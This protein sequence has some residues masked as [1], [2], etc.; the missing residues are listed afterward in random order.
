MALASI[1][2]PAHAHPGGHW[3][4]D[5]AAAFDTQT[6]PIFVGLS[7]EL[8]PPADASTDNEQKEAPA[9]ALPFTKFSEQVKLR[10]DADYLYVESD[11]MPSH[12]MMI[13]ITAWQQQVPLPQRYT[14]DNAWQIPLHPVPAREP[15]S[16]KEHFF[17]GAIALAANGVPIFNPIKNDGK[18]DTFLAGELD[19]Y[20][21][22]CGRADDYHYHLPPVYLEDTVGKGQPIAIALDGYP[23]LGYVD[24]N[25]PDHAAPLD[26]FNGHQDARGNYHYH[27]TKA[28]P[29]LNGG[30]HGQVV[31]RGG[32][33]DPQP[34]ATGLRPAMPP[35]RGATITGFT[36]SEDHKQITV[37]YSL[38]DETRS[39]RATINN[40]RSVTFHYDNG[41]EGKSDETYRPHE[42]NKNE[43][44]GGQPRE[45]QAPRRDGPPRD[46]PEQREPPAGQSPRAQENEG[47][48][49]P[50]VFVHAG[51]MDADHDAILTSA[52]M[53]A[54]AN[55]AFAG[56]DANEDG[57]I[58][59]EELKQSVR[60]A[61]GGFIREHA[62]ELDKDHDDSLSREE[63]VDN[64]RHMFDKAD[65]DGD[66]RI[67]IAADD[68]PE[69]GSKPA[70]PTSAQSSSIRPPNI[71][72]ILV[73]DMG[74]RD[75]GFAGNTFVETP[76]IDHLAGTGFQFT[77]AYASAPNC[78]P[79]RACFMS[80]QY[81][82][83][84]GIYTV[85]DDRYTPGLPWQKIIPATS[86][87]TLRD[88]VVTLAEVLHNRGYA[89]A[90]V[91]MWNLGRG[92]SGPGTPTGQGFDR[93]TRPQDLG[94]DRNAYIAEDGRYLTDSLTEFGLD[95]VNAN[96]DKPFFLYL[97]THAVHA[98]LDPKPE[99]LEK[100]KAKALQ[101]G[102]RQADA[103]Y[104][105]TIEAVDQNVGRIIQTLRQLGLDQNTLVV[106]TSDNGGTPQ[107]VAPLNGSKGALYEGGIRVPC[108]VWWTGITTP[109]GKSD[110]P[111]LTMDFYPT[112]VELAG[113]AL[114]KDQP[115]DGVS[116]L[117]ILRGEDQLQ[118][119][120]VFW[121]FPCYIGRGEPCSAVRAGDWK[122]L[123]MFEGQRLELY[124]LRDDPGETK[125]LA[126]Q[127]PDKAKELH[128]QLLNWQ[129]T[130]SAPTPNEPNPNYDP[131]AS[132]QSRNRQGESR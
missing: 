121:H 47:A 25:D 131:A 33:V 7:A 14:G 24:P 37:D 5:D 27:A 125:N 108:A 119:A 11:S 53:L 9:T 58:S 105:A 57:K 90:C 86:A 96:K 21:G 77:Q 75:V 22:H 65:P 102:D 4:Q 78:A 2:S 118:R 28:Y 10:W 59:R 68:K 1:G 122:L 128:E 61:M 84:H 56:Y 23:I 80:G 113:A 26:A 87:D 115:I 94:F 32:Q 40:D 97:A 64:A 18:T 48:R 126:S 81:T 16:A 8:P 93:F 12:P 72:F 19:Q 129:K 114:P 85:V 123:E 36:R 3:P 42:E 46:R 45:G 111:I 67:S 43:N 54:E 6:T 17:R 31:E 89:T 103:A 52:E 41:S 92:K 117:P 30:F 107:Y 99:L 83:R 79:T 60:S 76:N 110:E 49:K 71:V 35:L 66:G 132:R 34:R 20:G 51:E 106:L 101:L 124:N 29:Y 91:G 100:Y 104:A 98:P 88:D 109:G 130:L 127:M 73:D 116:L 39:V 95:F 44:R 63:V 69:A 55:R 38:K 70:A 15:M 74:W 112:L 120:A 50:W 13:G 62:D 82:P